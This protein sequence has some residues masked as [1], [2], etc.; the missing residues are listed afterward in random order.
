M[1]KKF[2][3]ENYIQ[4]SGFMITDLLLSGN[5]LLIY[6]I[7]YGFSQDGNSQYTGSLSYLE[8]ATNSSRN[9]VISTLKKLTEKKLIIREEIEL[10]NI[11]FVK[12]KVSSAKTELP[13][14]S[15]NLGSAISDEGSAK[16]AP[17]NTINNTI[18]K[19]ESERSSDD[20]ILFDLDVTNQSQEVKLTKALF[21]LFRNNQKEKGVTVFTRYDKSKLSTW[22]PHIEK[23][24]NIDGVTY[25]DFKI[26]YT[27]LGSGYKEAE[28]WKKNI[29]STQKLRE[30][31]PKL[32]QAINSDA[33]LANKLKQEQ[34]NKFKNKTMSL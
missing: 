33:V 20:P 17:N 32:Q 14:Q 34:A 27:W 9:T 15:L 13:V 11:K 7:I 18:N 24:I 29:L 19:E 30:Q 8:S 1:A 4:I 25:E 23:M 6:A 12:Y 5:E 2:R 16:T 31:Y 28:F 10:N 26:L 3:R 21:D 22:L